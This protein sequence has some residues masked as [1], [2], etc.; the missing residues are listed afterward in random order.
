MRDADA[1]RETYGNRGRSGGWARGTAE[2]EEIFGRSFLPR[3][4]PLC[5]FGWEGRGLDEV[6][7][8]GG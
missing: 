3:G 5:G 1:K 8:E 7:V 6:L 4:H 2:G